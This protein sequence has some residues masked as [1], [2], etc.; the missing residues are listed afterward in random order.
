M[1]ADVAKAVD[2]R[3]NL[4]FLAQIIRK[5][6]DASSSDIEILN[7][8]KP[9]CMGIPITD[10]AVCPKSDVSGLRMKLSVR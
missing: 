5:E 2:K 4:Y 9:F 1:K 7:V 10:R 3:W 6:L 8:G